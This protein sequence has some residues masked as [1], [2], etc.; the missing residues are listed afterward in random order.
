MTVWELELRGLSGLLVSSVQD[1]AAGAHLATA[2]V[3]SPAGDAAFLPGSSIRGV[4]REALRRFAEARGYA[5]CENT[6]HCTC[7]VCVLFGVAE[8]GGKL[9][10]GSSLFEGRMFDQASVA[11]DRATRTAHRAGRALWTERRALGDVVVRVEAVA[12]LEERETELLD[13]LWAWLEAVG[14]AVGQRRSAGGGRFAVRARRAGPRSRRI[15]MSV[16][17]AGRRRYALRLRLEEPAHVVGPR[18][19]D[20][21]RDGL[22]A[23]P[24]STVRGAI[25]RALDLAGA[26]AVARALFIETERPVLVTPAFPVAEGSAPGRAVP[27]LSRRRCRGQPSHVLDLAPRVVAVELVGRPLE[28]R[29]PR[30]G[31][32]LEE[33]GAPEPPRLVIGHTRIDP[34]TRRAATGEL[35][36]EVALAPG[37]VF[38]AQMVASQDEAE[39]VAA[40]GEVVVGGRRARGM[41]RATL[42]V[43]ELPA[44]RPLPD[45]LAATAEALRGHGADPASPIG[46]VGLVSDVGLPEPLGAVMERHGLRVFAGEARTVQRGGWDELN[47]QPRALREVIAAGSWLAVEVTSVD[48]LEVLETS[49]L[50]DPA[51][52]TP[53]VLTV[54]DDWEVTEVKMDGG[55][56]PGSERDQLIR[57]IRALCQQ[58]ARQL[59]APAQL[60]NIA[61]YAQQT[62]SV[63]EVALFLEYQATR[64]KR[65]Q[66]PFLNKLAAE[67]RR[68]YP[69]DPA[70]VRGFLAVLVRAA[71]VARAPRRSGGSGGGS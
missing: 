68:R 62:D 11:I 39:A 24:A 46:I 71:Q 29:C 47:G 13:H 15:P 34:R 2:T 65:E 21:Y 49:G 61:R 59:P 58:H 5:R 20:F 60:H 53:L 70:G 28:P 35:H 36:Y 27:W 44:V 1:P 12:A 45:R 32:P 4:L 50:P 43:R 51:G 40:L 33:V 31:A 41:G 22:S 10:V 30:C 38:E 37:T 16:D 52:V 25:G 14:V 57:E 56:Q 6:D 18:Q 8:R 66:A 67:L 17:P 55:A 9:R 42:E 7:R 48:E 54:R 23:I 19:R 69:G 3:R 26:G 64:L 63:E